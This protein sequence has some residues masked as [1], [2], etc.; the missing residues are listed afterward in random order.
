MQRCVVVVGL[1]FLLGVDEKINVCKLLVK[2]ILCKLSYQILQFTL[3]FFT[4]FACQFCVF[5]NDLHRNL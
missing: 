4:L 1:N 5:E 3:R 2:T